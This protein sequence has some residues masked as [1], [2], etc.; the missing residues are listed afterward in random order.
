L[1]NDIEPRPVSFVFAMLALRPSVRPS[2]L[3]SKMTELVLKKI[4]KH[5]GDAPWL[6]KENDYLVLNDAGRIIGRIV[7]RARSPK[8]RPWVWTITA[9]EQPPS[10][11]N[12]Q[13]YS[14]TREQA[15]KDF[16][17]QYSVLR[18]VASLEEI[19][20]YLDPIAQHVDL[21]DHISEDDCAIARHQ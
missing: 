7:I 14:E 11:S 19:I 6:E 17:A 1:I 21:A 12:N 13:G 3:V 8:E 2:V 18:F 5:F 9:R 10:F 4:A 16:K 15:M 20:R